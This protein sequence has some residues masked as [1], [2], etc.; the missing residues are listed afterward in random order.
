MATMEAAVALGLEQPE[1]EGRAC[2]ELKL[3]LLP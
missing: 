3:S 1:P 2:D